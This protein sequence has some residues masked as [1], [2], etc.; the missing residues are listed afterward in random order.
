VKRISY[1]FLF[2]LVI[3]CA[4][5]QELTITDSIGRLTPTPSYTLE[6]VNKK[7]H[8]VFWYETHMIVKDVDGSDVKLPVFLSKDNNKLDLSKNDKITLKVE[9]Y[10]PNRIIYTLIES[11]N[12]QT[13]TGNNMLAGKP[14]SMSNLPYRIYNIQIPL[15]ENAKDASY[16]IIVSEK[17]G[18]PLVYLGDFNYTV[19]RGDMEKKE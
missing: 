5:K 10:N 12:Y 1:L 17:G 2:F 7:I 13:E 3:G 15:K 6:D 4:V 9:I 18:S 16:G 11:L 19:E 14:I 8:A